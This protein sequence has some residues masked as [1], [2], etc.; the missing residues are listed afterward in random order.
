MELNLLKII[1][2][3]NMKIGKLCRMFL[4]ENW[5]NEYYKNLTE[6]D[7]RECV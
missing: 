4:R 5:D 1:A 6:E 2:K 7:I 3:Q